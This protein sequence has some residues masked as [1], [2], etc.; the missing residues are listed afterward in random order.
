[1]NDYEP[2]KLTKEQAVLNIVEW[3]YVN[4]GNYPNKNEFR[5]GL[6]AQIRDNIERI[7]TNAN[8]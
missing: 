2:R 4:D 1:M 5:L 3:M 6:V 8:K 7:D